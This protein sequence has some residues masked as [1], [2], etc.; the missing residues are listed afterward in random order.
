[1]MNLFNDLWTRGGGQ[2]APQA[3]PTDMSQIKV[4]EQAMDL[5]GTIPAANS[6]LDFNAPQP[7]GTDW[8]SI[9]LSAL[10]GLAQSMGGGGGQQA[11][12][13][14]VQMAPQ[15]RG[16]ATPDPVSAEKLS[17]LNMGQLQ[18]FAQVGGLLSKR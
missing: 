16:G 13:P 15:Y 8:G 7:Q 3:A 11:P 14:Q 9:G 10:G 12:A 1:M 18:Q 6:Q 4:P 2:A 5:A 17:G